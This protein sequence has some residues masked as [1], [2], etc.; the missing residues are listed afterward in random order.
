MR[1]KVGNLGYITLETIT[2]SPGTCRSRKSTL[3]GFRNPMCCHQKNYH[4]LFP[5]LPMLVSTKALVFRKNFHHE[6]HPFAPGADTQ[7][8][9]FFS[10]R[11]NDYSKSS[12]MYWSGDQLSLVGCFSC[13]VL[14]G[15]CSRGGGNW[16]TL[17]I[18]REDWGTLGNIRED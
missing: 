5:A 14:K 17:R 1:K 18:P 3:I 4:I 8:R 2:S 16:G 12:E 10:I 7:V 6:N 9:G 13:R 15:G 11:T